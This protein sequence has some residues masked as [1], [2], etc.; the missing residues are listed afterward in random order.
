MHIMPKGLNG[1]KLDLN[2]F[3]MNEWSPIPTN[4]W[5]D[6]LKKYLHEDS[7]FPFRQWSFLHHAAI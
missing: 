2:E 3:D 4:L 6:L 5:K 1:I 7:K